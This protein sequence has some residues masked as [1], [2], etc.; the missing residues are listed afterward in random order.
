MT[1]P[2]CLIC[3]NEGLLLFVNALLDKGLSNRGVSA[4]IEAADGK[5]DPDVVARHRN[6]HYTAPVE[7]PKTQ[8][9][10]RDLAILVRDKA[11]EAI[12][13]RDPEALLW[14]GKEFAPLINSGLRA[15]AILDKREAVK[16]KQS[17]GALLLDALKALLLGPPAAQLEDGKTVEGEFVEVPV[18]TPD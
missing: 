2:R 5:L 7:A 17:G 10:K 9:T 3:K 12:E 1:T 8:P 18:G 11:Y 6:G 14:L 13:G 4:A 15:E 16:A